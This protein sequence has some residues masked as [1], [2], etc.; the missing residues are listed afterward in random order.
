VWL[1]TTHLSTTRPSPK[2]DWKR[3]RPL[4]V[5]K[6]LGPLTYQLELP[7]TYK[8]HNVFHVSLLTPLRE[9]WIPGQMITPPLP[10][11]VTQKGDEEEPEKEEHY[12]M[13]KYTNS[14]WIEPGKGHWQFQFQVKWDGYDNLTWE[15]HDTLNEDAAKTDQQYL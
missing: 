3:V 15:D 4:K 9:D 10:L 12:I 5:L 7:S 14:Q 8:I 1:E 13:E 2:L 11:I 6:R